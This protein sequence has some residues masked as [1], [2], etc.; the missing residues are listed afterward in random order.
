MVFWKCQRSF[1]PLTFNLAEDKLAGHGRV[2]QEQQSP[3]IF[4][5][6]QQVHLCLA[7]SSSQWECRP[8][9]PPPTP[10]FQK[11]FEARPFS[12][13][14]LPTPPFLCCCLYWHQNSP[15]PY[16]KETRCYIQSPLWALGPGLFVSKYIPTALCNLVVA[17]SMVL[18][19]LRKQ[20][21]GSASLPVKFYSY[22][23][24]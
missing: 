15:K 6:L 19:T 9:L 11:H 12:L 14:G 16:S 8:L 3:P 20:G 23:W 18:F 22:H 4:S 10:L 2:V 21:H 24:L 5:H 7:L 1:V 17:F 13:L